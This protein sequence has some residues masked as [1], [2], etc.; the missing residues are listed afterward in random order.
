MTSVLE[1]LVD[2]EISILTNDG[3][4]IVGLLKGYDQTINVVL[5]NCHE[6]VYSLGE[7][8]QRVPLGLYIVRG[9]NIGVIG[10]LDE[11]L[12]AELDFSLIRAEPM[13]AIVH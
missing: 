3:R 5:H 12:E 8:V 9:D 2:K 6:R 1:D 4:N 10:E 7:G 11:N 13:K